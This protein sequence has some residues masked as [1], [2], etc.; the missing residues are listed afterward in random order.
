[1]PG[2]LARNDQAHTFDGRDLLS[3]FVMQLARNG[4]ALLLDTRLN[5][6]RQ[7]AVSASACVAS[8]ACCRASALSCTDWAIAL[9]A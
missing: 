5:Q 9:K 2:R 6:L 1:M 8:C 3:E 7:F 4:P